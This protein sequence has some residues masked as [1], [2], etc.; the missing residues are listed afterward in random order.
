MRFDIRQLRYAVT[1][2]DH[3]SFYRAS[4]ALNV[5]QSTLSRGILRLERVIGAKLFNRSRSGITTTVAGAGFI[6][7]AR[8]IL[9]SADRMVA[10]MHAAG[11]G[12]AGSLVVGHNVPV[13]AGNLRAAMVAWRMENADVAF[14]SV[15]GDRAALLAGLDTGDIDIAILLGDAS[16]NGYRHQPL[17]S[18]RVLLAL[19]ID[20]PLASR[21][22][23]FWTELRSESF[24]LPA[25]D[26][27]TDLQRI[28]LG[29]L[30]MSGGSPDLTISRASRESVLSLLGSGQRLSLVCEGSSGIRY[31][32]VVLRPLHGEQGAAFVV[33]SGYWRQEN[34]NPA[35]R[36]F[37]HFVKNRHALSFEILVG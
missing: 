4:L 17:W 13:S 9:A 33:H 23:L 24:V 31:P 29:R 28:L 19:P 10:T 6:R 1:A 37:L 7:S 27:G 25:T 32:D 30:S 11:Q 5:E 3:G 34:D 36:R 20:H 21:E 8:S 16:R 18:E 35:L 26:P 22:L 12:R 14:E 15:E 2:A